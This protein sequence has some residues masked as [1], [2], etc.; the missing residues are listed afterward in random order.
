MPGEIIPIRVL[1]ARGGNSPTEGGRIFVRMSD[2]A[3][4][5]ANVG[6]TAAPEET[7]DASSKEAFSPAI[8][9]FRVVFVFI[10]RF[11]GRGRNGS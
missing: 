6:T 5:P 2:A 9:F 10:F 7:Y 11:A 8:L 3:H 1:E 4:A